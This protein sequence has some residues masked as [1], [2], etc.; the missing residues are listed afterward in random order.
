MQYTE[1]LKIPSNASIYSLDFESLYTNIKLD[2]ALNIITNFVKDKL[3]EKFINLQ[4]FHA[5]LKLFFEANILTF[6]NKFYIQLVGIGMGSVFGPT[7]ANIVVYHYEKIWY[8]LHPPLYYK[9]YID[10]IF[11]ILNEKSEL[12]YL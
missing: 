12:D 1:N 9:R 7:C 4:G 11:V 6:D 2:D 3:D 8:S 5:I 10:D